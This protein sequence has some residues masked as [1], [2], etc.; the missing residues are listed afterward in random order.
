MG[1]YSLKGRRYPA[2]IEGKER[3]AGELHEVS[4]QTLKKIDEL[5][6][7]FGEGHPENEYDKKF[8]MAYAEDGSEIGEVPVY[9]YNIRN[10]KNRALLDQRITCNDYRK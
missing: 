8:V 7:Y 10:E 2:L 9:F 1:F 6:S 5:E 4:E 3:I